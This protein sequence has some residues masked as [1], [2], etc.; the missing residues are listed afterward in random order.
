MSK[1]E[2]RTEALLA[3]ACFRCDHVEHAWL[4][5]S[6]GSLLEVARFDKIYV[7]TGGRGELTLG[8]ETWDLR[9]GRVF[10]IPAGTVQRGACDSRR[11]LR[12]LWTHFE[13]QTLAAMHL[14]RM[15]PF[16]PCVKGRS[17]RRI[18]GM[19]EELYAEW[20]SG[21]RGRER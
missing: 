7:V 16:P 10:L 5:K 14:L 19:A 18:R 11:G 4:P 21:R 3:E 12:I 6:W 9:A 1:V 2:S 15:V 17:A 20:R 8:E 13:A